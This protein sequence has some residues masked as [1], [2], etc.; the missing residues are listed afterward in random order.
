[1]PDGKP[2]SPFDFQEIY[3]IPETCESNVPESMLAKF[4]QL[5]KMGLGDARG[6]MLIRT[7]YEDIYLLKDSTGHLVMPEVAVVRKDGKFGMM[8][9]R[10]KIV[11]KADYDGIEFLQLLKESDKAKAKTFLLIKT[12]MNGKWGI[13]NLTTQKTYNHEFESIQPYFDGLALVQK[14]RKFGYINTESEIEISNKYDFATNFNNKTAI[15]GKN[16]RFGLIN[17]ENKT[18]I[19]IEYEELKL[20]FPTETDDKFLASLYKVRKGKHYGIVNNLGQIVVPIEYDSLEF[21]K[22]DYA[23]KGIKNGVSEEVEMT[24]PKQK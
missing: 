17:T 7:A 9:I 3:Y 13:I 4:K 16:N 20:L 8:E 1:M 5:G 2:I 22:G 21:K 10:K 12:K 19:A 23:G 18:I 15:V 24:I 14:D 11:L 6:N